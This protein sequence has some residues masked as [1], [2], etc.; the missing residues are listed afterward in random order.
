MDEHK[1]VVTQT[2]YAIAGTSRCTRAIYPTALEM[3][4]ELQ[5]TVI[6]G[7]GNAVTLIGSVSNC[8]FGFGCLS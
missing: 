6:G 2:L 3:N 7:V 5:Y 8:A 4:C 1:T